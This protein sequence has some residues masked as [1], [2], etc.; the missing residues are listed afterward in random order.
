MGHLAQV[1][2]MLFH[3][4]L[5]FAHSFVVVAFFNE[6]L[7]QR[8]V[9]VSLLVQLQGSFEVFLSPGEVF[10]RCK[11]LGSLTLDLLLQLSPYVGRPLLS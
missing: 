11:A 5:E 10:E 2:L 1:F 4:T 7:T 8:V 9:E 3:S 6:T